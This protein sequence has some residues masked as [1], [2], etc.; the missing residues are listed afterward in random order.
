MRSATSCSHGASGR[1]C[2]PPSSASTVTST[3]STGST[4]TSAARSGRS[5]RRVRNRSATTPRS[6]SSR[7]SWTTSFRSSRTSHA[8]S[9][10]SARRSRTRLK[11]PG[12]VLLNELAVEPDLAAVPQLLDDVPADGALIRAAE[13]REAGPDREVDGAVDLLVEQ[14]VP[15]GTVDA[16]VAADPE[17]AEAACALV[18]VERR[19][20]EVLVA[21]RR[22]LDDRAALEA[23]ADSLHL[24]AAVP[25]RVLAEGHDPVRRVFDRAVEDL[26]GRHVR[27][28]GVHLAVPAREREGEV[29]VDTDDPHVFGGVEAVGDPPHPLALR[30]PV[31]QAGAVEEVGE[32]GRRHAGLLGEGGR[33]VHAR[34]PPDLVVDDPGEDGPPCLADQRLALR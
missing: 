30:V 26:A 19:E 2:W 15:E 18:G 24:V 10:C 20:Q 23:E 27:V 1:S 17:L 34:H 8:G 28:A 14:G 9:R 11:L 12:A 16:L 32:G 21:L 31:P 25:A 13:E 29:G 4:A 6:S 33:R 7:R 3:R 5:S 22:R